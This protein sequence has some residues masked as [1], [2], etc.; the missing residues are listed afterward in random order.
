MAQCSARPGEARANA[1]RVELSALS[2]LL[3]P[4]RS[5]ADSTPPSRD[6]VID[7]VRGLSLVVVVLGHLIM[8]MAFW[9]ED[10]RP[11]M[12]NLMTAYPTLQYLTWVLQVMP[13]F[14]AFGGAASVI[15]WR[16]AHSGEV[17]YSAWFWGRVRRLLRPVL[18]YFAAMALLGVVISAVVGDAA[19]PLLA[20][21]AAPLWF[22]GVYLLMLLCLPA[23]WRLHERNRA[24]AF[25]VLIPGAVVVSTGITVLGWPTWVGLLNYLLVWLTIQQLGFF[26]GERTRRRTWAVVA[27]A[28]FAANLLLVYFGPWPMSLVGLPGDVLNVDSI[29]VLGHSWAVPGWH[30]EFSNMSPPSVVLLLHG[31]TIVSLVF[32][33]RG[34]LDALLHRPRLWRAVTFVMMIAMSL[35]LWHFLAI[36]LALATLHRL[37]LPPPTRLAASGWPEP[38][39]T[40]RYLEWFGVFLLVFAVYLGVL[41]LL[42]WGTEYRHLPVW[43]SPPRHRLLP[44]GA[45]DWAYV[46]GVV[47]GGAMTGF[48]VLV[49]AL[50]GFAGFPANNAEWGGVRFNAGVALAAMLVGTAILR[51]LSVQP[52]QPVRRG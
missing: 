50:V 7:A 14:F 39:D 9:P 30:G 45:P 20:I 38:V 36:V 37:G 19:T 21:V 23:M 40:L 28:A 10:G 41:V 26:W 32:V 49:V 16:R 47:V 13:L 46:A 27:A 24:V 1:V 8:A 51:A 31:L 34:P 12:G 48:G 52:V 29:S 4:A 43:D 35:Y 15:A 2:V 25:V 6:R 11:L 5:V 22:L 44:A 3:P 17:L 33:A 18:V 42:T